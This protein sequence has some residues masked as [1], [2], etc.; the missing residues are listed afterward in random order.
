MEV[1]WLQARSSTDP[2]TVYALRWETMPTNQ[3]Q[4][5]SPVPSPTPLMWYRFADPNVA[6]TALRL[7]PGT[8]APRRACLFP[9]DLL[10]R[11]TPER[12]RGP[13]LRM[14]GP[15]APPLR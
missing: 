9:D 14:L 3:D 4:P 6:P 7:R 2:A 10:G 13:V 12:E 15:G 8:S 1:H 5:R 11:R